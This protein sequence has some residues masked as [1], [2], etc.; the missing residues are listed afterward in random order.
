VRP[1]LFSVTVSVAVITA[2]T[3][4]YLFKASGRMSDAIEQRLPLG[5]KS[6]LERYQA[7]AASLLNRK[8]IKVGGSALKKPIA[9]ILLDFSAIVALTIG[10]GYILEKFPIWTRGLHVWDYNNAPTVLAVLLW[11]TI[12]YFVLSLNR[13]SHYFSLQFATM[14]L[15]PEAEGDGLK[16]WPILIGGLRIAMIIGMGL[17][18]FAILQAFVHTALLVIVALGIVAYSVFLHI[19]YARK[20][21]KD[22]PTGMKGFLDR[23]LVAHDKGR[24]P[25]GRGRIGPFS[26]MPIDEKC[27]W[28]GEAFSDV[29]LAE[30]AKVGIVALLRDGH[31]IVPLKPPPTLQL[32]DRIVLVGSKKAL[33]QAEAV[34][35]QSN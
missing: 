34:L 2:L 15:N 13:R 23:F 6:A 24:A 27:P 29:N 8:R 33:G 7:W 12:A 20:L 35:Y 19:Y 28:L 17:P 18:L 4:M 32:N 22:D 21:G 5:F 25:N 1:E 11:L 3:S 26:I 30:R 10:Y 9:L 16:G 31:N 14:A